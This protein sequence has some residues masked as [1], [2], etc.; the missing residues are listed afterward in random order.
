[1]KHHTRH[2]FTLIELLVV[3]AIIAIL[4]AILFPVFAR[5]RE[6]AR[7]TSC[8]SN[9][10]QIVL[11]FMMYA[12]DYDETMPMG[13]YPDWTTYWDTKVDWSGNVIGDGLITPYTKNQQLAACPSLKGVSADRPYSGYAYNV[14]YIGP[15]PGDPWDP[16]PGQPAALAEIQS[17]CET[18]L[19]A[20]SAI[21]SS[22]TNEVYGNNLLR[23]PSHP[24]TAW[25]PGPNVHFRHNRTANVGYCDGHA[26]ATAKMYHVSSSNQYLGHLSQGDEAYDLN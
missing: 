14:S 12:E 24:H 7:Q 20:D 8:L 21:W 1:M 3:I 26:K 23:A 17:P 2:A 13:V 6:K 15:T 18:V 25:D 10:K 16:N 4:A 5:A 9:I 19:A 11:A 22:F